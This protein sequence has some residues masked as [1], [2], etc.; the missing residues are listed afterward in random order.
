MLGLSVTK[1]YR[2]VKFEQE[3]WLEPYITLKTKNWRAAKNKFEESLYKLL[4]NSNYG[5][6]Y[7]SKRKRMK[8]EI[9]QDSE[10]T[11]RNIRKFDFET[12]EIFSEDMAALTLAPTKIRWDV[13]KIVGACRLELAM[14]EVYK[15]PYEVMKVNSL[16]Y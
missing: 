11:I 16:M 13:P 4:I 1:M 12:Y 2:V 14:F 6:I 8:I 7:E 5:K 10:E 9:L 3:L 15:F